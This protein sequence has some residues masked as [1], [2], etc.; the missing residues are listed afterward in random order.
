M[1]S[2]PSRAAGGVAD[3]VAKW[4]FRQNLAPERLKEILL[5]HERSSEETEGGEK[6]DQEEHRRGGERKEEEEEKKDS[7]EDLDRT[8]GN[9][10]S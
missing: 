6:E 1:F 8:A 7:P 5:L 9:S 2:L 4:V 10:F 3:S